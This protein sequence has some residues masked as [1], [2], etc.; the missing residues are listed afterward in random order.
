MEYSDFPMP[1][2]YPDFPHHTHIAAYFDAYVDHFGFRDRIRFETGVERAA[3]AARRRL[4][5]D[6]R[7]RLGERYD[8]LLVAN[9]HHWDPRWPEPA[10]PG[11]DSFDGRA[12]ARARLRRR[13]PLRRQGR[14][15]ARH[16]QLGDGHRGRVLLRARATPTSPRAAAPGSSPS[17]C[18][19]GPST[20]SPQ[21]PRDPVQGPPAHDPDAD[22]AA[23]R[24]S[25]ALRAAASPTTSSARPTRPSPDASSTASPTATSR[26][27]RTSRARRRLGRFADG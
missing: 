10:F 15:R 9:G 1:K 14:R 21:D 24:R 12:D 4:G 13:R 23:R 20:S 22:Q 6:A 2:S 25:R 26:R 5:A 8:A 19:A 11:H 3:A 18:S 16:G 27:S 7:R 17:T